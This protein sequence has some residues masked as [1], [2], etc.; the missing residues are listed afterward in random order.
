[1]RWFFLLEEGTVCD[2]RGTNC[3]S[4]QIEKDNET[5]RVETDVCYEVGSQLQT[6]ADSN[7]LRA[8]D[9][10]QEAEDFA[11]EPP[12][13]Q[14]PEKKKGRTTKNSTKASYSSSLPMMK[15]VLRKSRRYSPKKAK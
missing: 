3:V 15:V 2:T 10:I 1:M 6:C 8:L 9:T 13:R 4:P 14:P 7:R 5:S 12:P 11:T